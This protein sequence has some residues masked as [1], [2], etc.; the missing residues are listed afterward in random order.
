M[1]KKIKDLTKEEIW[2]ICNSHSWCDMCPLHDTFKCPNIDLEGEDDV[3]V[4]E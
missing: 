3:E 4:S 1:R 2:N